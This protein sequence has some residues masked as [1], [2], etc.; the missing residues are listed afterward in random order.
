LLEEVEGKP[1][2]LVVQALETSGCAVVLMLNLEPLVRVMLQTLQQV[3]PQ[4][5]EEGAGLVQLVVSLEQVVQGGMPLEPLLVVE[6]SRG[7]V[8]TQLLHMATP[9]QTT[10]L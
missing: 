1:G 7:K 2:A 3:W 5:V 6:V 4:V 8:E 10:R 9:L